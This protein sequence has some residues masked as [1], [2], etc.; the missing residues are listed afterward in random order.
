[1]NSP[2]LSNQ[3]IGHL[4][5]ATRCRGQARI[6]GGISGKYIFNVADNDGKIVCAVS[7]VSGIGGETEHTLKSRLDIFQFY[8]GENYKIVPLVKF[9]LK[10]SKIA[11]DMKNAFFS[12]FY[13]VSRSS[14]QVLFTECGLTVSEGGTAVRRYA[15]NNLEE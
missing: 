7:R 3:K 9:L 6:F 8:I 1:M 10:Q 15:E 11:H 2:K 12:L 4:R 14:V 13:L 5:P